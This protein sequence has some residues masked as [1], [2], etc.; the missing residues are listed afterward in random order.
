MESSPP[1]PD[2][3]A[4]PS[5]GA[6][7]GLQGHEVGQDEATRSPLPP[8]GVGEGGAR[9][10]EAGSLLSPTVLEACSVGL[11]PSHLWPYPPAHRLRLLSVSAGGSGMLELGTLGAR[12]SPPPSPVKGGALALEA[13]RG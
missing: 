11:L 12:L 2:H 9:G 7:L 13:G 10:W 5:P 4:G 1:S 6:D 3:G 8:V